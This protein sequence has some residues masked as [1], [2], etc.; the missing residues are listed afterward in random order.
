MERFPF[1]QKSR[2]CSAAKGKLALRDKE[3]VRAGT[4]QKTSA[5]VLGGIYD[6]LFYGVFSAAE[7]YTAESY[8]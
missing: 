8:Y 6:V 4:Y 2:V 1:G 5:F 7:I 3:R